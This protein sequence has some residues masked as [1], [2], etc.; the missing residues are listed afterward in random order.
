MTAAEAEILKSADIPAAQE[1]EP[2]PKKTETERS[3]K[4]MALKLNAKKAM[5]NLKYV[6]CC[7]P[8]SARKQ[9]H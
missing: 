7:S 1:E 8:K 4:L 2:E 5:K 3:D 9:E 6:F